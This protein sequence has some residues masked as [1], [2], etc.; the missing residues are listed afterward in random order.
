MRHVAF[1]TLEDRAGYVIDDAVA[2]DHLARQG[3]RVDEVPWRREG[4]RWRDY[5]GVV[6]RTTWDYQRDLDGF[7]AALARIEASGAPLANDLATVRW[8]ARKTYLRDLASRGVQIVPTRWGAG[9]SVD[10][11]RGLAEGFGPLGGV[12]KPVVS[13][14]ADDTFRVDRATPDDVLREISTTFAG[15]DWMLQPFV[16]RVLDEG[17]V[18]VFYFGGEASH[19][20][21]KRPREGDFRVQEEHGG[22]ITPLPLDP[23]LLTVTDRVMSS[24]DRVPLQARVDLVRLD[25]GSLALM[26]LEA[27]EPSLYFRTDPGAAGRF[28]DALSR[29][30]G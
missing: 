11:L 14:N 13:A 9:I 2:I 27:I 19:A 12:I 15:R 7:L 16:A 5:D 20:I 18:S 29:W 22:I 25:D 1:L 30:L 6:I 3:W 8:N 28:A 4:V 10:S 24:L 23:A 17:E 26:E 21:V